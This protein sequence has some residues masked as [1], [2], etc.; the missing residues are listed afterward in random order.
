MQ[1]TRNFPNMVCAQVL[2]QSYI[3]SS[4]KKY[5]PIHKLHRTRQIFPF[6]VMRPLPCC[7]LVCDILDPPQ[8]QTSLSPCS[9]GQSLFTKAARTQFCLVTDPQTHPTPQKPQQKQKQKTQSPL[10]Y[11]FKL[12]FAR[13]DPSSMKRSQT[14]QSAD[15]P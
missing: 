8:V 11:L 14:I 7:H 6:A 2:P 4:Y 13:S 10:P 15:D 1:H 3:S 9:P 12:N 5:L